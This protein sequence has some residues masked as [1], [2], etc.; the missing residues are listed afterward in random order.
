MHSSDGDVRTEVFVLDGAGQRHYIT[1]LCLLKLV[2]GST[3]DQ[4]QAP[5]EA[6]EGLLDTIPPLLPL[7]TPAGQA[8]FVLCIFSRFCFPLPQVASPEELEAFT[9]DNLDV[10]TLL[11]H[12]RVLDMHIKIIGQHQLTSIT[13]ILIQANDLMSED[14]WHR[15]MD[16]FETANHYANTLRS[17]CDKIRNAVYLQTHPPQPRKKRTSTE[18]GFEQPSATKRTAPLTSAPNPPTAPSSSSNCQDD[19]TIHSIR[20]TTLHHT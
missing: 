11:S 3:I 14:W 17:C 10:P 12:Q 8:R 13:P 5:N 18:A 20:P 9:S 16:A 6:N 2:F 15:Y 1:P 19:F 7:S 4:E